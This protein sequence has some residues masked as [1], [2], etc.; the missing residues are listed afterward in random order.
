MPVSNGIS[1]IICCYNSAKRLPKTLSYLA[2]QVV[3]PEVGWE[4]I[5]IDNA[6]TDDT[7]AVAKVHREI[8]GN[9]IPFKILTEQRAGKINALN[10][11][12]ANS[13]YT[14][15]LICDDDNWLQN[16]YLAT[17]YNLLANNPRVGIIG[18]RSIAVSDTALPDWFA[19]YQHHYAVG[20]QSN[21]SGPLTSNKVLWGAG[22]GIRKSLY[23]KV[24]ADT[25]ALLT[26]R[27]GDN[28][29]SGEDSEPVNCK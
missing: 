29:I 1:V 12:V 5:I 23:E 22:M 3:P 19:K 9:C 18:G 26:G 6:S 28:L 21:T 14:C 17:A 27:K 20:N 2:E 15:L 8:H 13:Q 24:Y 25:P 4:I 16:D 7:T 10:T 11:G